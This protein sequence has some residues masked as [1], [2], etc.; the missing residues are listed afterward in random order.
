[1][2]PDVSTPIVTEREP[3]PEEVRSACE[4]V[5]SD[6]DRQRTA[7]DVANMTVGLLM[8]NLAAA[9]QQASASRQ[10]QQLGPLK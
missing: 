7:V 3:T 4:T 6:M 8:Q 9:Q 5:K 10:M 1:M 2:T